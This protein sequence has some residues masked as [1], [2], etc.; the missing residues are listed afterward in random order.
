MENET[1]SACYPLEWSPPGGRGQRGHDYCGCMGQF[2]ARL[3]GPLVLPLRGRQG[4]LRG[5]GAELSIR[6]PVPCPG[7]S[8]HTASRVPGPWG[9]RAQEAHH[10]VCFRCS[11]QLRDVG[12]M[13][14]VLG[15][16]PETGDPG[17]GWGGRSPAPLWGA[18]LGLQGTWASSLRSDGTSLRV[19]LQVLHQGRGPNA[20]TETVE[21]TPPHQ[22]WRWTGLSGRAWEASPAPAPRYPPC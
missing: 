8:G 3:G 9:G 4:P 12:E 22:A 7:I 11:Q 6:P 14:R 20:P 17:V 21:G 15:R 13:T 1:P 10:T 5:D 18:G 19:G 16:K 2:P